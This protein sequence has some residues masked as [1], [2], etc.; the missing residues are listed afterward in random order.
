MNS[1]DKPGVIGHLL[2]IEY[3]RD[4][5][6][7]VYDF[8]A[9]YSQHKASLSTHQA[10]MRWYRI[11]KPRLSLRVEEIMR[12]VATRLKRSEKASEPVE[13]PEK[14]AAETYDERADTDALVLTCDPA[15]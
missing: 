7:A 11:E 8:L 6:H 9:G 15:S 10:P 5:G 4:R 2:A 13:T 14:A 3:N 12:R 1:K